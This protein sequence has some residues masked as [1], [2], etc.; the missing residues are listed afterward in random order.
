M[1]RGLL[2]LAISLTYSVCVQGDGKLKLNEGMMI[3]S[4]GAPVSGGGAGPVQAVLD[5]QE[6]AGDPAAGKGGKVISPWSPGYEKWYFPWMTAVLDLNGTYKLS[7]AWF[8]H[9]NGALNV[10][11]SFATENPLDTDPKTS[12]TLTGRPWWSVPWQ[13]WNISVTARYLVFNMIQECSLNELVLYGSPVNG[14]GS[15][16]PKSRENP[17]YRPVMMNNYLGVNGFVDDPTS[18]LNCVANI[19][20]YQDWSWTEGSGD[21]GYPHAKTDFEPSYSSFLI[22]SFY[23]SVQKAGLNIHQCFQGRPIYMTGGNSSQAGW[24]PVLNKYVNDRKVTSTAAPWVDVGAHAFQVAARYGRTKVPT[25]LLQLGSNQPVVVA[26]NLLQHIEILNECDGWWHGGEG[27]VSPVEMA[28]MLSAAYDGHEKTLGNNVGIKNA[29]PTMGVTLGGMA[30]ST[31]VDT[32]RMIMY[33]AQLN[34]KDK[35]LPLDVVNIHYYCGYANQSSGMS[36]EDCELE[37]NMR[38]LTAWRDQYAP[39]LQVWLTEF[40][41][42]T[43]PRSPLA[44]HAYGDYSAE[45]VQGMW[46]VRGFMAGLAAGLDRAHIFMLRNVADN[47][48]GRFATSGLTSQKGTWNPKASWYYVSTLTSLLG[49]LTFCNIVD[50]G[51]PIYVYVFSSQPKTCK[52]DAYVVWQGTTGVEGREITMPLDSGVKQAVLVSLVANSTVGNQSALNVQSGKA[53][54]MVSEMPSIVLIGKTPTPPTGPV[55]PV[56]PAPSEQCETLT[57]GLW[58]GSMLNMSNTSY[59]LCP[60]GEVSQCPDG[61]LCQQTANGT[62]ACQDQPGPCENK[63][64]G[65]YCTGGDK[66]S[67]AW[68]DPYVLCP[69]V[70]QFYCPTETPHCKQNGTNVAC[71]NGNMKSTTL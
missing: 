63:A 66:P 5:E 28:A 30:S 59:I 26:A 42:D 12:I 25:S 29:D 58:C 13:G 61:Q 10:T 57:P 14:Q 67:P 68:G 43:D 62:I 8:N 32:M 41:W 37:M 46:L 22:D 9:N 18:R 15:P 31:P 34:R 7:Q 36:P 4:F 70:E 23:Q 64:P 20:E 45:Q 51:S 49:N 17:Y 55:P 54:F 40:G 53:K 21:P 16:V 3:N 56:D 60:Q 19:R 33:W 71:T 35:K 24:K 38:N 48:Y 27:Y 47:G 44:A 65:L 11:V 39:H 6:L 1:I 52:A 69:Q 50:M 2:F